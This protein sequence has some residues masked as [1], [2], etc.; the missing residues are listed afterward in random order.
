MP[1]QF[2]PLSPADPAAPV[3]PTPP[4]G[5]GPAGRRLWHSVARLPWAGRSDEPSLRLLCELADLADVLRADVAAHGLS[6]EC[7]G[8]RYSH[9]S[10]SALFEVEKQ[11]TAGMAAFGMTP[12]SRGKLG[13]AEPKP[14]SKFEL[15]EM[16]REQREHR[17]GGSTAS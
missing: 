15:F 3:Q 14:A 12:E 2:K 9:P 8:R 1:R 16:R 4:R 6:Y 17:R 13:V 11:I 7:R 10:L 5:F